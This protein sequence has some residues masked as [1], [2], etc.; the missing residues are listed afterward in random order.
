M[1]KQTSCTNIKPIFHYLEANHAGD[2]YDLIDGLHPEIDALDDP[3]GFLCDGNNW[4]STEV[5]VKLLERA[6]RTLKDDRAAYQIGRFAVENVSLGYIQKIFVKAFWSSKMGFTHVQKIND[7]FNRSKKV[8]LAA[9]E[10]GGAV[11]RLHW[12]SSMILSKDICLYNQGIYTFMPTIWLGMPVKLEETHCYFDGHPYCE[13]HITWLFQHKIREYLSRFFS[14]RTMLKDIIAEQEKDKEIIEQK[15]EE[16]N[17]LNV[18]LNQK[19]RQVVAIQDTGKA[20]LSVLDLSQLLTVILNIVSNVCKLERALIMLISEDGRYLK[21]MHSIGF[22][23]GTPEEVRKYKVPMNRVSN[24]IAR[25]ANT[26][27]SEYIPRVKDSKLSRENIILDLGKPA[28][29]YVVPLITRSKVIG[30][31]ATDAA[32]RD[33]VPK[34]IRD[35]M[36]IFSSQIAIAIENARLYSKL[37][38]QMSELKRSHALLSRAERFSFLGNLAA[39]LAHEIK[40]PMTAIGTF[41]QLLPQ[42]FDDR[43]FRE[44]FHKIALEETTRVN[45]L[46]TELLDLAKTRETHFEFSDIHDLVDKMI[47]LVSPESNAKKIDMVRR[48]SP[49]ISQIWI[50]Y[51]KM[52]EVVLNLLS[53]AVEFTPENGKIEISTRKILDADGLENIQMEIKDNG[54]GIPKSMLNKIFDPYFTTK[55]KSSLHKGTGLGLFIAHKNMLDH[56]GAVEVKSSVNI[57]TSFFLTLPLRPHAPLETTEC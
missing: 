47:L 24:I 25:V 20:I 29:V 42:K 17:R 37:N 52:K 10:R 40:N 32:D 23:G 43:E 34:E 31:I 7:K 38:E 5:V 12:D 8:E 2:L 28:S 33:G 19:I 18:E 4:V 11:I 51:E 9:I 27:K 22:D 48:Y 54:A 56:G 26:G 35:T 15:Y 49:N 41:L 57:G 1:E 13:Y 50:D 53:N 36:E 14:S 21:Y 55:H 16:V 45:N 39:R 46:I 30:V 44:E 3:V 6:K